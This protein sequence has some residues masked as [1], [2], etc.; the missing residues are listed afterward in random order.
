[1]PGK[2]GLPRRAE[3]ARVR[4]TRLTRNAHG[5]PLAV[6]LHQDRFD[7]VTVMQ[8]EEPLDRLLVV[9]VLNHDR[10]DRIKRKRLCC[11]RRAQLLRQHADLAD[12][13]GQLFGRRP[14]ELL[15]PV[16]LEPMRLRERR[17]V[18]MPGTARL[19]VDP[20]LL[21]SPRGHNALFYHAREGRRRSRNRRGM[22]AYEDFCPQCGSP[23]ANGQCPQGHQ[24]LGKP[25]ERFIGQ[26]NWGAFCL[27]PLWLINHGYLW[28]GVALIGLALVPFFGALVCIP[29]MIYCGVKGN[30]IAVT[31][32]AFADD[33]QFVAVQNAWRNWGIPMFIGFPIIVLWAIVFTVNRIV[34]Q[35]VH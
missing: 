5:I 20:N 4:T 10:H 14:V 19:I 27:T 8:P 25:G 35:P 24:P 18:G 3:R 15:Q 22:G 33:A 30:E 31:R 26:W 1:M 9:R 28:Y 21:S 11:K 12:L 7:F 17:A 13:G 6:V 29:S 2:A 34:L 23:L 32:R 16:I